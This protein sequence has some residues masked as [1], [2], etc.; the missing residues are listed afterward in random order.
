MQFQLGSDHS[1]LTFPARL[2]FGHWHSCLTSALARSQSDKNRILLVTSPSQL[3]RVAG[4]DLPESCKVLVMRS[5]DT[6]TIARLD[7]ECAM[8]RADVLVAFGGGRVIDLC[9]SVAAVRATTLVAIPST[10]SSDCVASPVCVVSGVD[11]VRS[12]PGAIPSEI[13]IDAEVLAAAP[14]RYLHAGVGDL[15]SNDSAVADIREGV[16]GEVNDFAILLAETS[17]QKVAHIE[18]LSMS[19][20]ALTSELAKGLILSGMAMGFAGNSAPCSGSEHLI[21]H[22]LDSIR[23]G[24]AL[25]GEQ[26]GLATLFV[27]SLRD[28]A[29]L[30]P[31]NPMVK[32]VLHQVCRY[33]SP[34]TFGISRADFISAIQLA[35]QVRPGRRPFWSR[36]PQRESVFEEAY[37]N[38]FTQTIGSRKHSAHREHEF[39]SAV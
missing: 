21:S 16:A 15:L 3:D 23:P 17:V 33:T 36:F 18:T 29:G 4:A 28:L 12:L 22:A 26:V 1:R 20:D 25:H 35:S 13:I 10:L 38:A 39:T 32:T 9:K 8:H 6:E 37:A 2:R 11:G 5:C 30:T 31:L 34:E 19:R 14:S 7:S 24:R 27:G